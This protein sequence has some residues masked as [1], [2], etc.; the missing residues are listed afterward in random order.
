IFAELFLD[1]RIARPADSA[2]ARAYREQARGFAVH[3]LHAVGF[4][5]LN[6]PDAVELQ[7]LAF[8]HHVGERDEEVENL[9]IPFT[10]G[11]LEGL[12][13]EPGAGEHAAVSAPR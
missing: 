4:G 2:E 3:Q 10:Q 9:E 5:D 13:V 6:L 12:H 1:L 8:D 7:Q 11:D